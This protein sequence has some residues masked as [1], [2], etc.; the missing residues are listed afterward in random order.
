[1]RRDADH[2]FKKEKKG[3]KVSHMP[4]IV[5]HSR[6]AVITDHRSQIIDGGG[7]VTGGLG[8]GYLF[9]RRVRAAPGWSPH[10][11]GPV[12]PLTALESLNLDM[13]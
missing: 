8:D 9:P 5:V 12:E 3:G 7:V 1:M 6:L 2:Y 13:C 11:W 4:R 10:P